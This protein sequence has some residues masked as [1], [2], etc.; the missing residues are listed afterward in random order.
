MNLDTRT[1]DD[2]GPEIVR[3]E[4]VLS[5]LAGNTNWHWFRYPFLAEGDTPEK[6]TEI[7]AFLAGRGYRLATVTMM[8]GDW[9][10]SEPYAR[11]VA[12]GDHKSI[13]KLERDYLAAASLNVDYYHRLAMTLYGRDIPYV[14]LM[15]IG[16]FE[17][18]TLPKLLALYRRHGFQFVTLEEAERDPYYAAFND[19]TQPAPPVDLEHAIAARGLPKVERPITYTPEVQDMCR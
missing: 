8:F 4:P 17:A 11:C 5:E 14:L 1:V 12:K 6:R 9:N 16:A 15:H 13:A 18:K 3:N 10:Y 19:P 7:R 2:Y